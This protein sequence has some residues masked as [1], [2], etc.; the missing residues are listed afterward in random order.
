MHLFPIHTPLLSPGD[1]LV[2]FLSEHVQ[3]GDILCVS[4]KAL[5]TVEGR[6]LSFP[7]SI[8]SKARNFAV[9]TG[10]TPAFCQAVLDECVV[11]NGVVMH[12]CPGALLTELRPKGLKEGSILCAN[13]GLDESNAPDGSIIGWP[14][15]PVKSIR[16]LRIGL[17]PERIGILI[18]DSC[19]RP[20]RWGV[21]A[22]ALVVSCFDPI[23]S[24][25]GKHDLF[26]RELRITQEAVADQLA[27][28][29]N[30][31][32]GNADQGIPAV[33]IRDHNI[34]FTDFEGW[35]PAVESEEDIFPLP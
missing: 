25:V 33:I 22:I 7:D 15:D 20:R 26:G 35:V 24:E 1:D 23:R 27:T 28:A 8:T 17:G 3:K 30:A 18:S 19:C 29:S 9:Q 11:R 32:M 2:S 13:A 5:A 6:I 12:W 10:R 14:E 31:L 34:P 21:T 16:N 4:S